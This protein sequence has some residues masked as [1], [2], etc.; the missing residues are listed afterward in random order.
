MAE[1]VEGTRVAGE[2]VLELVAASTDIEAA[3]RLAED[4]RG[5]LYYD[6]RPEQSLP[7]RALACVVSDDRDAI[8]RVGDVGTYVV[9]RRV[10]KPG[11][12]A[13]V[14]LFGMVRARGIGHGTAD[15]HWRDV[16]GPLALAHHAHMTCYQQLSVVA[17][18]SGLELDGFALCGFGSLEDLRQRF[19]TT[20][21]SEAVIAADVKRFADMRRSP[22]RLIA[23]PRRY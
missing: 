23:R 2:P 14:A 22:R 11:E 8:G 9:A 7:F 16:H 19:Y 20:P 18:L 21:D 10:V 1:Q 6:D 12:A 17:N 4:C 5:T 13:L 3:A 15:A